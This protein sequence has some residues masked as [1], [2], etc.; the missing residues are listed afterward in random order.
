[1]IDLPWET[2]DFSAGSVA[3]LADGSFAVTTNNYDLPADEVQFFDAA[4]ALVSTRLLVDYLA[5]RGYATVGSLGTS[6]LTVAQQYR[7]PYPQSANHH[8]YAQLYDSDGLPLGKQFLWSNSVIANFGQYYRFGSAPRWEFLPIT[9]ALAPNLVD[10][11]PNYLS[12]LRIAEPNR[13]RTEPPLSLGPPV[14][15][16]IE[17]AAINGDGRFVVVSIAQSGQRGLQVFSRGGKPITPFLVAEVPQTPFSVQTAI[18]AQGQVL[19]SFVDSSGHDAVRLYDE[20]GSPASTPIELASGPGPS[21]RT[22]DMRGLDDGSFV[23]GWRALPAGGGEAFVVA[24][25]DSQG[26]RFDAPLVIAT[27]PFSFVRAVLRLNGDGTGVF[28]W[29]SESGPLGPYSAHARRI[30]VTQ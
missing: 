12:S 27:A 9:Y 1:V 16:Q 13:V 28:V 24:R 30:T 7:G 21:Y 23:V 26:R 19:S 3:L 15:I 14:A 6:Y 18:N 11:N 22:L 2:Q 5:Y 8:A 17:D 25:F 29:Q 4:G 10:N 20:H